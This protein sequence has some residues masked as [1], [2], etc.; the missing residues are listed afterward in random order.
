MLSNI[1]HIYVILCIVIYLSLK[2]L[3]IFGSFSPNKVFN[4]MQYK[5]QSKPL[6]IGDSKFYAA[7]KQ[8]YIYMFCATSSSETD[9][10]GKQ[11]HSPDEISV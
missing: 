8:L 6:D 4:L 9:V 7:S 1:T 2:I 10:K 3:G 11:N 5:N